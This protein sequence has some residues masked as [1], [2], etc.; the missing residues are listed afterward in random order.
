MEE[1]LFFATLLGDHVRVIRYHTSRKDWQA[2]LVCLCQQDDP[3]LVYEYS[4]QLMRYEPVL[5]VDAWLQFKEL[6]PRRLIPALMRYDVKHNPPPH[7]ENQA[8]RYLQHV[9][10]ELGNHDLVS[11]NNL[12]AAPQIPIRTLT[13]AWAPPFR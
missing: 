8:I 1:L 13:L 12:F 10:T 11:L 2:A 7:T 5:A 4:P 9:V 6:D 3:E